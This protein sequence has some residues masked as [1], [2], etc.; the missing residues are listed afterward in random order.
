MKKEKSVIDVLKRII[1]VVSTAGKSTGQSVTNHYANQ[2]LK[3]VKERERK[4]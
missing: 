1:N 2:K 3:E 4:G